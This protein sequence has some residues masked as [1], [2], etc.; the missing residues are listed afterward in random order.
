MPEHRPVAT[1]VPVTAIQIPDGGARRPGPQTPGV[2]GILPDGGCTA[3]RWTGTPRVVYDL[4]RVLTWAALIVGV[5]LVLLGLIRTA[6][7]TRLA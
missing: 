6:Q 1:Q 5:V 2:G 7:R 4:L 3:T